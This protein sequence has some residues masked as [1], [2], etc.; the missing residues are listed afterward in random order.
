VQ[1]ESSTVTSLDPSHLLRLRLVVA[2]AGE[3]DNACWWNTRG[4]LGRL[5]GL[6]LERGF[7]KTHWFSQARAV[8][9]VATARC[10][11]VFAP[12]GCMTLWHLPA[13]L[14]EQFELCW[15]LWIDESEAWGDFFAKIESLQ[16]L[17]LLSVLVHLGLVTPVGVEQAKRL[18]R[19]ADG[20]AVPLT[21]VHR[22]SNEVLTLLAAGFFRGE[23]GQLAVPYARTE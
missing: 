15:P 8:F 14:E 22:P 11:E 19:G 1:N 16:S 5:G 23:K 17:D 13:N 4:L 7:P 21:G 6:A 12:P 18:R 2:R 9:A 3:M 10:N 20:R